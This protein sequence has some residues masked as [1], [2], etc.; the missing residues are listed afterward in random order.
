M[1]D[2]KTGG[3]ADPAAVLAQFMT[4]VEEFLDNAVWPQCLGFR[5]IM[6]IASRM[7][8]TRESQSSTA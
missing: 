7:S 2:H 1:A 8:P 4:A 6:A 3:L 5:G